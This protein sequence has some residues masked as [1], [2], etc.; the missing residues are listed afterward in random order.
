MSLKKMSDED[1]LDFLMTS[2]FND[3]HSPE[4]LRYLLLKWRYFYRVFNGRLERYKDD[5]NWELGRLNEKIENLI[6]EKIDLQIKL[7]NK[8]N[9]LDFLK[10]R[11]LSWIERIK[12]KIN[13]KNED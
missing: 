1:L 3:N 6:G 9:E 5:S 4:E 7:A 11:K 10:S 8:E 2:D 13:Y 12:G